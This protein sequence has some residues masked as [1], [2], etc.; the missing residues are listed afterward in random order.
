MKE[1]HAPQIFEETVD[2]SACG[3]LSEL[4]AGSVDCDR[5]ATDRRRIDGVLVGTLV[6]FSEEATPLVTF[7]DQPGP[8][9]LAARATIDLK[10]SDIGREA[11]LMFEAGDPQRPIIIGCLSNAKIR[12]LG[13][14]LGRVEVESD[15]QR[16]VVSA[17][18]RIVLRCGK[19]SIT[20]TEAGKVIIQGAY[21]S[22]QSS[23]VLRIKGGSVQ[24][25]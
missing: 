25:N 13:T 24:I 2:R 18:E 23:G 22:N 8:I 19:A 10:G 1:R 9:A 3:D 17:S 16:L 21:L 4:L 12:R 11:V 14:E 15:G 20:L 5:T 6:G 7:H